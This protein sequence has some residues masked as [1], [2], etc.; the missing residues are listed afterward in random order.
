MTEDLDPVIAGDSGELN[1]H[2]LARLQATAE[3]RRIEAAVDVVAT[4]RA[5]LIVAGTGI[6]ADVLLR[7]KGVQLQRPL[8]DCLQVKDGITSA[9]VVETAER[10]LEKFPLIKK[11]DP[12]DGDPRLLDVLRQLR[13]APKT[14]PRSLRPAVYPMLGAPA[15]SSA[16]FSVA[17]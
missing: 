10:L 12:P 5:K 13:A 8:E 16:R 15:M 17:R 1:P 2:F 6:D 7:L 9:R 3:K 14:Q 11:I 4:S